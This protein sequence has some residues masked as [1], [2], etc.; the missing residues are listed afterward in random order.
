[1]PWNNSDVCELQQLRTQQIY[2][3][4]YLSRM[5]PLLALF[6]ANDAFFNMTIVWI[7]TFII[8][9]YWCWEWETWVWPRFLVGSFS[10]Y[11]KEKTYSFISNLLLFELFHRQ[12]VHWSSSYK[13]TLSLSRWQR[14]SSTVFY[15]ESLGANLEELCQLDQ[16]LPCN[17]FSFLLLQ[18]DRHLC[19]FLFL[20]IF[21]LR[22]MYIWVH[23]EECA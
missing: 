4:L 19:I 15:T 17:H 22:Y 8:V 3:H 10:S 14:E 11:L 2:V 9:P 12:Q 7:V 16:H 13:H 6:L 23:F 18:V 1:M 5:L 20:S 21:L